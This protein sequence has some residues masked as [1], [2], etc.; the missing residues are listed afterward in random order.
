M[1]CDMIINMIYDM[2]LSILQYCSGVEIGIETEKNTE[3]WNRD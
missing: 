3:N 1:L 2:T